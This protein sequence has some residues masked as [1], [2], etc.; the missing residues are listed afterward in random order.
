MVPIKNNINHKRFHRMYA[1]SYIITLC[2]LTSR[3][4]PLKTIIS[5]SIL[6][7]TKLKTNKQQNLKRITI[8]HEQKFIISKIQS[9]KYLI[10]I[11]K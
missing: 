11:I 5:I 6:L 7:P 8:K 3:L 2:R 10:G 9:Q 1:R 4:T